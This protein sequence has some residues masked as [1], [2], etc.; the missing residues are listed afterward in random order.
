MTD[1]LTVDE[2][3]GVLR[4]TYPLGLLGPQGKRVAQWYR[5][6]D[7]FAWAL[8]IDPEEFFRRCKPFQG[9]VDTDG[10]K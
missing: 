8:G 7:G 5:D 10:R 1:H 4:K 2:I 6:A 3:V 9:E